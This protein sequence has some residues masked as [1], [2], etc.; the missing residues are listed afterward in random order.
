MAWAAFHLPGWARWCGVV[1]GAAAAALIIWTF[2]TLGH[3]LTDTVV[4]RLVGS[5]Q[6]RDVMEP[7]AG[8]LRLNERTRPQCSPAETALRESL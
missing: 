7:F 3:N 8:K 2:R 6:D 4:T 5:A 1:L